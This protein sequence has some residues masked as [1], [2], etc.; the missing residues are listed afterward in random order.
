[1]VLSNLSYE[2]SANLIKNLLGED[3]REELIEYIFSRASGNPFFIEELCRQIV[4][5]GILNDK[6]GL[7]FEKITLPGSIEAV[8]TA[9]CDGLSKEAKYLL[10]IASIIGCSFPKNLLEEIV[11]EKEVFNHLGELEVSDLLV[12]VAQKNDIYYTFRH[13]IFQEVTY[14][15]LLKSERIIYHKIIAETIE[16]KFLNVM[17]GSASLLAHHYHECKE[18][19]KAT[20]FALQAGDQAANLYANEEATRHYELA[21]NISEDKGKKAE[22]LEKLADILFLKSTETSKILSFYEQARNLT[23][24]RLVKAR[25]SGKIANVYLRTGQIDKGIEIMQ[26]TIKEI[27]NADSFVLSQLSYQLA[28]ILLESKS[29]SKLAEQTADFGIQV[30]KKIKDEKAEALGIRIK[31][32]ILWRQGR[33][34]EAL[35][36][37]NSSL[38]LFEKMEDPKVQASFYLLMGSVYR[39]AG[40]LKKAIEYCQKSNEIS[41]RI[42]NQRFLALGYNNLGIYYELSG[43]MESGLKFYEKSLEIRKKLDD[44]RGEA[45]GYFN[46]GTLRIRIGEKNSAL[47]NYENALKIARKINDI[48]TFFNC[49]VAIATNVIENNESAKSLEYLKEAE[50]IFKEKNEQWM[51]CEIL[52][53][54]GKY[55]LHTREYKKAKEHIQK[56]INL[57]KMQENKEL[58]GR[59][60]SLLADICLN[61]NDI[62]AI[63]YAQESLKISQQSND[64]EIEIYSLQVLGKAQAIFSKDLE[65]GVKLI[66]KAI[67]LAKESCLEIHYADGLLALGEVMT[68]EKNTK[69]ALN[70]LTQA[71][72]IYQKFDYQVKLE[73]TK[74]LLEKITN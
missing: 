73:Q 29:E 34:D 10:K 59:Y 68:L 60:Y 62:Q 9:R 43:N 44:K 41:Q 50:K 66:K 65:N 53:F 64:K 3:T 30:A 21:A 18:F 22:A 63:H 24:D 2:A 42:G 36:I 47:E 52:H 55:F 26:S 1:L 25:I 58:L 35:R 17:E 16:S 12:R 72:K 32:Q 38:P 11:K 5:T 13:P 56:A 54:Y 61:D 19:L 74:S 49:L 8:V 14:R 39:S 69:V 40:D 46:L 48:R 70:Y 51:E 20:D 15:S 4:E 67:T 57:V 28:D 6:K 33:T 37:M 31:A 7:D 71:R 23:T 27:E 45:I